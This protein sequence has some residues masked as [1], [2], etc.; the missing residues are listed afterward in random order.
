MAKSGLRV[1]RFVAI[2]TIVILVVYKLSSQQV[3][4]SDYVASKKP[5]MLGTAGSASEEKTD[6]KATDVKPE[7]KVGDALSEQQPMSAAP[8]ERANA[9]FVTLA[10]NEDLYTLLQSIQNVE[11]RFNSKYHYSWVFLNDKEFNEEFKEAT[12]A[13][14]SGETFYGVIP[15]DHWGYP[16]WIDQDKAAMVREEMQRKQIIYGGSASYRHMCRFESGFFWRHPL[17]DQFKYYWRVEPDVK[18]HCDVT[19]DL[20]KFMRDNK[21]RYG[22]TIS[23]FEYIE[24][25]PT[26]WQTTKDF[27]SKNPQYQHEN[28][29]VDFISDD[30]GETYNKCHF[31][32]NFEIA[33]LDFWRSEAYRNYFEHLDHAGGFFYERWGDAPVHSLA[34]SLFLD[35]SEVHHFEDVGY[36]HV[37]FNTCPTQKEDRLKLRCSCNPSENFSW[38]GYSCTGKFYKAKDLQRPKGWSSQTE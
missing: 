3:D 32:S 34:A 36:F 23:L 15:K 2:A 25:I 1:L 24:T 26:L 14:I 8:Y 5:S 21:K 38:K 17:L 20:F 7:V 19:Y 12:S 16:E 31:W 6:T 11:D 37:P 13:M 29:L 27:L 35:K 30:G 33:D 9:T 4:L 28:A 22:F 10:R 18:L